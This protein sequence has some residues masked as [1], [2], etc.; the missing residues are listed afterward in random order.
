M[1]PA[2]RARRGPADRQRP[3]RPGRPG[4]PARRRRGG[5]RGR[6][7]RRSR[8]GRGRRRGD[9][10][11]GRA[12]GAAHPDADQARPASSPRTPPRARW[13]RSAAPRSSGSRA[14]P[15]CGGH[16]C[17]RCCSAFSL[18]TAVGEGIMGTLFTPYVKDVLEGNAATLGTVSSAQAVGGILGGF[19]A[20]AAATPLDVAGALRVGCGRLRTDRPRDLL[21][22][23]AV[24]RR[25][26]GGAGHGP[27]RLPRR[28]D[29]RRPHDAAAGPQHGRAAG[30]HLRAALRGVGTVARRR[31]P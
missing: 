29:D 19:V 6:G 1:L 8:G 17:S 28:G 11:A 22:P 9:V 26:A 14:R 4:R 15:P 25:V 2:D 12:A 18:I 10:P 13:R 27:G 23:G 5:R 7:H 30:P 3:Q 20:A 31:A 16:A 21:L 24:R